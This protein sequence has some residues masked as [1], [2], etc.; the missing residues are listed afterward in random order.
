MDDTLKFLQKIRKEEIESNKNKSYRIQYDYINAYLDFCFGYPDFK[1]AKSLCT[2]YKEFPLTH[3]REKFAEIQDQLFEYEKKDNVISVSRIFADSNKTAL[4]KELREREPKLTFNI[5]N[6]NGKITLIHSNI[7]KIDIKF[8]FIDL[9][10]MFTRDP[11]ISEL[12]NKDNNNSNNNMK[13]KFGFVQS[14]YSE[15]IKIPKEKINKNDNITVYDIKEEFKIKN[16]FVE[17]KSES[18]KLFDICLSSNLIVTIAENLG[19]LKVIDINLQSVIKAYIKVYVELKNDQVQFYKDGYTD[20]NGKFNYLA[21]NTD[22]LKNA[23]KFYIF[24]SQEEQYIREC[25][26]PKNIKGVSYDGDNILGDLQKYK[27]IQRNQWRL[28]NNLGNYYIIN[29]LIFE[30]KLY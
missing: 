20:L 7:S 26:P 29:Y 11:K 18:I 13:E 2:K 12:V 23:K 28:M 19:E 1:I 21:L 27:Q 22:Q 6:K 24:L 8:Y 9:E 3:W 15:T 25:Y 4:T 10:T 5:D 17:I 16:L 14:N 30:L